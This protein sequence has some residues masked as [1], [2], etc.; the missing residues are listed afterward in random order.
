MTGDIAALLIHVED[1][2]Q[3][4]SWYRHAFPRAKSRRVDDTDFEVLVIGTTHLELVLAD[5]QVSS[6]AAGTVVYW[7]VT[8]L[9]EAIAHFAALG[10]A[11]YRGP[12]LIEDCLWMCQVRDP[13]GNCIGLRGPRTATAERSAS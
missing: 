8:D 1:I 2:E 10:A 7:R 11:V 13:W 5:D 12:L 6:G 9:D 3:G 4:L